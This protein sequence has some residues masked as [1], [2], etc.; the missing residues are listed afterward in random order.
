MTS[1][2]RGANHAGTWLEPE[3]GLPRRLSTKGR[4][5]VVFAALALALAL[6][7]ALQLASL[8]SMSGALTAIER[9]DE[10]EHLALELERQARS[11][12][13]R[14]FGGLAG[15]D[16]ANP[17]EPGNRLGLLAAGIEARLPD[18]ET[19]A[20]LAR[21]RAA[22]SE[23]DRAL[24]L[25]GAEPA[26][27]EQETYRL[28]Y[29]VEE[30]VDGLMAL[31]QERD[32]IA[33]EA[34]ARVQRTTLALALAFVVALPA[35]AFGAALYLSRSVARPLRAL[36]DGAARIAAG[37]LG[38]RVDAGGPEEFDVL[39]AQVN[40]MASR[41]K[42]NQEEL[43]RAETL[44]GLGRMAAGIAHEINNPLQVMLGYLSLHRDR[45]GGPL[46]RDLERVTREATRCREIVGS[47]LQLA[48]PA[49]QRP[50]VPVDLREASLEV[51]GALGVA[52]N[53]RAPAIRV[54]GE[55]TALGAA[56]TVQQ[57][58]LNLVR[59]AAE[60]AGPGG[61]VEIEVGTADGR[62][63]VSVSDSGPGIP[64]EQRRRVFDPFFT[65]K[66][67]G[68]GLGLPIARSAAGAL[69]GDLI[70]EPEDGHGAGARFTLLLPMERPGGRA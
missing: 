56:T 45:V 68:T 54:R 41:L 7:F 9:I 53:G 26:R 17:P 10:A 20:W 11:H 24:A 27:L 67:T 42:R 51:A 52:L 28:L 32:A 55:G 3:R 65:T 64:T 70:L 35:L 18:A 6:V 39:A 46:G 66:P 58:L 63:R 25:R 44:A 31:L 30:G 48:R 40:A 59:N 15:D 69:G 21:I 29:E 57:I 60:A 12:Y 23:L 19:G 47:L 8:E 14:R 50:R 16:E 36:G 33:C 61:A 1:V 49:V 4:L 13:V 22:V 43:V 2:E 62:A 38:T 37:D 5:Y 34:V